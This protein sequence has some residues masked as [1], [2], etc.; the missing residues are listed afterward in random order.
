MKKIIAIFLVIIIALSFCACGSSASTPVTPEPT[1]TPAPTPEI[2][3][4]EKYTSLPTPD[5]LLDKVSFTRTEKS[6]KYD[7]YIYKTDAMSD[8]EALTLYLMDYANMLITDYGFSLGDTNVSNSYLIMD[9]STKVCSAG[10]AKEN[11][12][13]YLVLFFYV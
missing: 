4:F 9:G 3:F 13:L 7:I 10:I 1:P 12:V 6:G 2:T 5:S 11:N 8:I